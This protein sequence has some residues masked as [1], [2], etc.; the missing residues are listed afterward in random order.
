MILVGSDH[1]GFRTKKQIIDRFNYDD[2]GC[3][4]EDTC[5]Y[6]DIAREMSIKIKDIG[7]LLCHTGIGMSIAANRFTNLRAAL[8]TNNDAAYYARYHNDANVLVIGTK[9]LN[10]Q[11]IIN[12]ILTF[13]ATKF[14][15]RENDLHRIKK[16]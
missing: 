15:F 2:I 5:D 8:C 16:I 12:L 6:P 1:R 10:T 14:S 7:I 4:T 9:Y 13:T 3:F 11:E